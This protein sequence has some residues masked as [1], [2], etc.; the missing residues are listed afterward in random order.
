MHHSFGRNAPPLL[1]S[2]ENDSVPEASTG[3]CLAATPAVSTNHSDLSCARRSQSCDPARTG[4]R[5]PLPDK[6]GP[7]HWARQRQQSRNKP[8]SITDNQSQ[9]MPGW[10]PV[11][12]LLVN[13]IIFLIIYLSNHMTNEWS[14]IM[15]SYFD[16]GVFQSAV[17]TNA[18]VL[19]RNRFL[20]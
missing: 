13:P 18:K 4:P 3:E 2:P 10:L 6:N 12:Q 17:N 20:K 16:C 5:L 9:L 15:N 7:V 8:A 14:L 19:D 11:W 1:V